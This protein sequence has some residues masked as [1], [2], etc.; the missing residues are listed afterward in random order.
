MSTRAALC[1]ASLEEHM[2]RPHAIRTL[3]AQITPSTVS[4]SASQDEP[5]EVVG[6]RT[7]GGHAISSPASTAHDRPSSEAPPATKTATTTSPP[8]SPPSSTRRTSTHVDESQSPA[9]STMEEPRR[10]H[11]KSLP[12][13]QIPTDS[14]RSSSTKVRKPVPNGSAMRATSAQSPETPVTSKIS[15]RTLQEM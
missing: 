13:D 8:A 2:Q 5:K 9:T 14:R 10:E 15:L 12:L 6:P 4:P 7:S 3:S 11:P 1:A